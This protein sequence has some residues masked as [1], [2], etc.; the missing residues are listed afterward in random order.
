MIRLQQLRMNHLQDDDWKKTDYDPGLWF[1]H[2][3]QI[4]NQQV[5]LKPGGSRREQQP[6][7]KMHVTA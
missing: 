6:S 4:N 7:V 3:H 2:P 1:S 5:Y